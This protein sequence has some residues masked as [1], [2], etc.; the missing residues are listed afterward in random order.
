M[1]AGLVH[2]AGERRAGS[3]VVEDQV[4]LR[5]RQRPQTGCETP[6]QLDDGLGVGAPDA[7][8][9]DP[10]LG[11][12]VLFAVEQNEVPSL[13]VDGAAGER[14]GCCRCLLH[15]ASAARR[16]RWRW[17]DAVLR[18]SST[19]RTRIEV[20]TPPKAKLLVI[21]TRGLAAVVSRT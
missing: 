19:A 12:R 6:C 20:F 4:E 9:L 8:Q 18:H 3:V 15:G 13:T 2:I 21:T 14:L 1:L 5:F 7:R 16:R 10:A 11:V 17:T